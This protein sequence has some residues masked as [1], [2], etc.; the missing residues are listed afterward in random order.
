[1]SSQP[2]VL[3]LVHVAVP[4]SLVHFGLSREQASGDHYVVP[5]A[6]VKIPATWIDYGIWGALGAAVLSEGVTLPIAGALGAT[7]VFRRWSRPPRQ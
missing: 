2:Y 4:S 1:M 7:A 5:L 3:P 6:H